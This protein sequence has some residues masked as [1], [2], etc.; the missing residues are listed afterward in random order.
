MGIDHTKPI[1]L[2][3]LERLTQARRNLR[4]SLLEFYRR[5]A[6]EANPPV[7]YQIAFEDATA[8]KKAMDEGGDV[9]SQAYVD[10][11]VDKTLGKQNKTKLRAAERRTRRQQQR[12]SV[13]PAELAQF[14]DVR[15]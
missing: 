2:A 13:A 12:R 10:D 6:A 4:L 8:T 14:A 9:Y 11:L 15:T 3:Q 5:A 7:S 1:K